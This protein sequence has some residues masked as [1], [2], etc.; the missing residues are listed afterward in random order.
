MYHLDDHISSTAPASPIPLFRLLGDAGRL[1]LMAMIQHEDFT[2]SE[3]AFLLAESQPQISKKVA[4]LKRA[5][6]IRQYKDGTRTFQKSIWGKNK[7]QDP[8][9]KVALDEGERLL[10]EE[11]ALPRIAQVMQAR[12]AGNRAY[13]E[14]PPYK[15]LIVTNPEWF[16]GLHIMSA[17]LPQRGLAVDA[18]SGDGNLLS[19]LSPMFEHVLAVE[20]SPAQMARCQKR[21]EEESLNNVQTF[22][23][24]FE[25]TDILEYVDRK[26][27]ADLV[28]AVSVM[29][30]TA[31][32][33]A[34]IA[35]MSRMLSSGGILL[36]GDYLPHQDIAIQE[37]RGDV[38]LGFESQDLQ[39]WMEDAG[40]VLLNQFSLAGRYFKERHD[41]HLPMQV[42]TAVKP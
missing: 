34:A 5:L 26:G 11:G 15:E 1:K 38:W 22:I 24:R 13:F 9:L 21:I 18:G 42:L 27:G 39:R 17:L 6:L 40:L 3:L 30:H 28:T 41:H 25:A 8:V 4:A 19:V 2:V 36:C 35:H 20:K 23:G 37:R 12:E 16:A 10:N 14:T 29:R 33:Q 32:P 31:S 7:V